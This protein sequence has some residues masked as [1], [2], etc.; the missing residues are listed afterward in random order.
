[1]NLRRRLIVFGYPA[2]ELITILLL[3]GWIGIG[4]VLVILALGVVIGFAIMQ[5][6]G[7]N[8]F[9]VMR[10]AAQ[11]GAAPDGAVRRHGMFFASGALIAIPGI[12]CKAAGIVLML[13]PVQTAVARRY[14]GRLRSRMGG[15]VVVE[16]VV[17]SETP[18]SETPTGP[19]SAG[20]VGEIEQR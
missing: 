6:A 5:T 17:V 2:L 12:W 8:A 16:G 3:A 19:A 20:P 13:P 14:A 10:E 4:W 7:R 9:A 11:S 15:A 1:M 18:V